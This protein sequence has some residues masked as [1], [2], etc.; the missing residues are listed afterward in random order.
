[1]N[2]GNCMCV[3]CGRDQ[4]QWEA[5]KGSRS[6]FIRVQLIN[7]FLQLLLPRLLPGPVTFTTVAYDVLILTRSSSLAKK[8]RVSS[9]D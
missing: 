5:R 8:K 6:M 9:V 3:W 1:M 2:A 7:S 4:Q